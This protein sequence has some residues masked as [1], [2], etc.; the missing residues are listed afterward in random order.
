[1]WWRSSE[2]LGG[3]PEQRRQNRESRLE[4][5]WQEAHI[6]CSS[7]RVAWSSLPSAVQVIG[8]SY[9]GSPG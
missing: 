2:R 9:S 1:M 3:E 6:G 4:N 8:H 7:L 5:K